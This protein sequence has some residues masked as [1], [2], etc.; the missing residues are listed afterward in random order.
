MIRLFINVTKLLLVS[1]IR[2]ALYILKV[3]FLLPLVIIR[4]LG[5]SR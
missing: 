2:L 4:S 3:M 5:G 1:P